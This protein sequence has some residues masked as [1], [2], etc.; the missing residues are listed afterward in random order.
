MK[1]VKQDNLTVA[2]KVGNPLL[3]E[4]ERIRRTYKQY[5]NETTRQNGPILRE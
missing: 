5:P 3:K 1:C 4:T 2:E